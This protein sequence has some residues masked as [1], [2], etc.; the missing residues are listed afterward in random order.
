MVHTPSIVYVFYF[1]FG[2]VFLLETFNTRFGKARELTLG[3]CSNPSTWEADCRDRPGYIHLASLE[4]RLKQNKTFI[5][6]L[7]GFPL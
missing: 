4:Q 2:S 7:R 3:S 5:F 1:L 6:F